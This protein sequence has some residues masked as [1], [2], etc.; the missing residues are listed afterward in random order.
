M[1][2]KAPVPEELKGKVEGAL[3]IVLGKKVKV[4]ETITLD[5]KDVTKLKVLFVEQ[6][7]RGTAVTGAGT[8][9]S[10]EVRVGLNFKLEK[11]K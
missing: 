7:R 11:A 10:Y 5:G 6:Y 9:I 4:K 1:T 8:T 3:D 2:N